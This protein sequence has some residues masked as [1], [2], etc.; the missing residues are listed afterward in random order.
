MANYFFLRISVNISNH[1]WL[2]SQQC[3]C[4]K[5]F[6]GFVF[7]H[8]SNLVKAVLE[9]ELDNEES[10]LNMLQGVWSSEQRSW[11]QC[12]ETDLGRAQPL[13]GGGGGDQA[14]GEDP[15]GGCMVIDCGNLCF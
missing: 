2:T 14:A 1:L 5:I 13:L 15:G 11:R 9:E 6:K 12:G 3:H 10:L 8:Q 4:F 7:R